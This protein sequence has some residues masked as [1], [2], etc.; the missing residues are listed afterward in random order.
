MMLD[1]KPLARRK[2]EGE[3]ASASIYYIRM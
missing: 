3:T 2:G 1:S